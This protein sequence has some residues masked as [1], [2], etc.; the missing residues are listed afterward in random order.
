LI[1]PGR[2]AVL[3]TRNLLALVGIPFVA[4]L[5]ACGG[6]DDGGDGNGASPGGAAP[7]GNTPAAASS[8]GASGSGGNVAGANI[9]QACQLLTRDEV[10]AALGENVA[11]GQ[12]G[13]GTQPAGEGFTVQVSTCTFS[14]SGGTKS[15]SVGFERLSGSN[16]AQIRQIARPQFEQGCPQALRVTGIGELACWTDSSH[17]TLRFLRDT[18]Q[19][20]IQILRDEMGPDRTGTLT[21]L[22]QRAAGRF[23]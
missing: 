19:V 10:Q 14:V 12:V 15:F 20:I 2:Y 11:E 22:A 21:G 17:K 7:G 18:T 8:P 9:Q 1:E 6:D 5:V 23:Q 13:G 4:L 3:K 16:I